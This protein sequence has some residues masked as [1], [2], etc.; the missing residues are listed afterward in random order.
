MTEVKIRLERIR[1][2]T[3]DEPVEMLLG[4]A[5]V[6]DPQQRCD[7]TDHNGERRRVLHSFEI[8]KC[9][10]DRYSRLRRIALQIERPDPC[11]TG[12]TAVVEAEVDH[13][14]GWQ[15]GPNLERRIQL[16]PCAAEIARH[17][18]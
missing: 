2:G 9:F 6:S 10:L 7:G 16:K 8:S 11:E 17:T 13:L 5:E 4:G 1:F 3:G 14:V 12:P 18:E 15:V